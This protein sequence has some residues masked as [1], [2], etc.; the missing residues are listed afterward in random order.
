MRIIP[1]QAGTTPRVRPCNAQQADHPRA[2]GDHKVLA[3]EGLLAH[4]SSPRR[5]GPLCG[6]SRNAAT[7]RI[8]PAQAGTTGSPPGA[9]FR[10]PDHPR[11]GGDHGVRSNAMKL[12]RGSS[13][14]RRGPQLADEGEVLVVRI[15]PAQAGTTARFSRIAEC[16][17]DHP[18]AGG[19]H[20]SASSP[21]P[22]PC[23]SSPRRRGPR[24]GRMG[25]G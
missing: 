9:R 20:A 7:H 6:G 4:G 19:D 16:R 17:P 5:R 15:I 18:R 21:A 11:A 25:D 10:A 13:P 24:S 8:I 3:R 14:R 22:S 1:A 2:G 23:G 12:S